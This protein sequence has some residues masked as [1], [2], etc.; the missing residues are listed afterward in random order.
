MFEIEIMEDTYILEMVMSLLLLETLP[1]GNIHWWYYQGIDGLCI[2][3]AKILTSEEI[4][5]LG[6]PYIGRILYL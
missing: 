3:E 6:G 5:K 1:F 2:V 4:K